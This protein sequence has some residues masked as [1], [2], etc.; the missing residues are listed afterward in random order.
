M[1]DNGSVLYRQLDQAFRQLNVSQNA[2]SS[3]SPPLGDSPNLPDIYFVDS[4]NGAD[5]NDGRDP[6]FPM[7]TIDAAINRTTASQGD[8]VMVQPGHAETLTTQISL[9]VIGVA[10]IGVGEGTLRPQITINGVIDGIDIGAAN[11]RVENIQFNES[12]AGATAMIN[13]DAANAVIKGCH[14][15]LGA[16]DLLGSITVTASGELPTIEDCTVIVTAD[17]PDEWVLVEGVVDRPVIQGNNVVCSDGTNAFDL[18]AINFG[19]VAATNPVVKD[20]VFLGGGVASI[21]IVGTG[22]VGASLGP[23]EYR[24]LAIEGTASDVFVPGF[25]YRVFKS[26]DIAADGASDSLYTIT[27]LNLITLLVGEVT[28]AIGANTDITIRETTGSV[29]IAALTVIDSDVVDTLYMVT[30]DPSD[31]LNGGVAPGVNVAGNEGDHVAFLFNDDTIEARIDGGG[32]GTGTVGWILYYIPLETGAN[33]V[34][35]A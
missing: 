11:C 18:G 33:V 6:G 23:N 1:N 13:V 8:I 32:G 17:G 29:G 10:I 25:G 24:G 7:A 26:A 2:Q 22:L 31:T 21:A 14:F 15:D 34:A 9:D 12:T 30:G 28:V 3:I 5:G 35:A 16:S 19:S 27:G 20:N 4:G